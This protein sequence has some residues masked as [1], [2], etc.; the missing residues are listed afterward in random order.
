[1]EVEAFER[2]CAQLGRRNRGMLLNTRVVLSQLSSGEHSSLHRQLYIVVHRVQSPASRS[3]RPATVCADLQRRVGEQLMPVC[4]LLCSRLVPGCSELQEEHHSYVIRYR[5]QVE[6]RAPTDGPASDIGYDEQLKCHTDDSDFTLN[7]C[8]GRDFSR[9]R[10]YFCTNVESSRPR[11]P[12]LEQEEEA[13]GVHWHTHDL[14][15]GVAHPGAAWHGAE[16]IGVGER[17]NLVLWCLRKEQTTASSTGWRDGFYRR[18][19]ASLQEKGAAAPTTTGVVE[20]SM[21]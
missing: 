19:E 15:V 13:G 3:L 17:W 8:L 5:S 21:M 12:E 14:G 20:G 18:L 11:T 4:Q 2:E 10:L 16:H 1:V 6:G 9:G 7:I